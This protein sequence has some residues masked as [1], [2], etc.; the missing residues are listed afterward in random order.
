LRHLHW[1]VTGP[2]ALI[3]VVF[4]IS[5]RETVRVTLWPFPIEIETPLFLIVL[6]VGLLGFLVGELVA[7]ING[8]YWRR[9]SR[10]KARRIEAL[11][12]ELAATQAQLAPAPA[13]RLPV[14]GAPRT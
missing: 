9:D 7:W 14:P 4:A 5:N 10:A 11:E 6:L 13:S 12:R 2:L 8:R 3:L 1:L